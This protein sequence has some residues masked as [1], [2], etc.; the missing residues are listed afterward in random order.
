MTLLDN[1]WLALP[2]ELPYVLPQDAEMV[3]AFNEWCKSKDTDFY[4]HHRL[5]T[6]LLPDPFIGSVS[7]PVIVIFANPGYTDDARAAQWGRLGCT[8]SDDTWHT[9]S[10][11]LQS[12]Y[13]RNY[14]Q[15]P[16]EYPMLFLDPQ[17]AGTPGGCWYR[18]RFLTRLRK[19]F[20]DR[21]LANAIATIEFAPYHSASFLHAERFR[22]PSQDYS[23][24][25]I[26]SAVERGAVIVVMR[27]GKLLERTIPILREI[28]YITSASRS[29]LLSPN[30]L[31]SAHTGQKNVYER[32]G[33][34]I[35]AS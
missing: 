7:A 16:M 19:R 3:G 10:E 30:N 24:R 27:T 4:W 25:L 32:I 1:P 15:E 11:V 35:E 28:D 31:K 12:L 29:P 14:A 6:N 22:L 2:N 9:E 17:M 20:D 18:H 26:Q 23:L 33:A 13:R 8:G 5:R 21:T 34:A